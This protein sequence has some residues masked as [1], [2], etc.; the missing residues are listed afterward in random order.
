[1]PDRR[2]RGAQQLHIP[3]R[4]DRRRGEVRLVED[5]DTRDPPPVAL[6][7]GGDEGPPW[8]EPSPSPARDAV[9]HEQQ[10]YALRA[11]ARQE[12]VGEGEIEVT[13]LGL[14]RVPVQDRAQN[15]RADVV[16]QASVDVDQPVPGRDPWR[17]VR[18]GQRLVEADRERRARRDGGRVR[19]APR[20]RDH[21]NH[22]D[23][24]R[25]D[26]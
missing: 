7:D 10:P 9:E 23:G 5:V 13:R 3:A 12:L 19:G 16:M 17:V 25:S 21:D 6:G 20:Q 22:H 2:V 15:S 18:L 1:M 26:D 11:V 24:D 4:R 14:G 8:G